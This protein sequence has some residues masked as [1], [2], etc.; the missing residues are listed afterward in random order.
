MS[1]LENV[2]MTT[3]GDNQD[4]IQYPEMKQPERVNLRT[5]GEPTSSRQ[6]FRITEITQEIPRVTSSS[7][8]PVVLQRP[9]NRCRT[10]GALLTGL[11]CW[12]FIFLMGLVIAGRGTYY[13]ERFVNEKCQMARRDCALAKTNC[14]HVPHY[15][16]TQDAA[17]RSEWEGEHK[18]NFR[19]IA[20][21]VLYNEPLYDARGV[22]STGKTTNFYV[23]VG[24]MGFMLSLAVSMWAYHGCLRDCTG[25]Q[26]FV[27]YTFD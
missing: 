10:V 19:E 15:C 16:E 20:H 3:M 23:G 17:I 12:T 4:E 26:R 24:A 21:R 22:K 2:E 5:K 18:L 14:N 13:D 8:R 27:G 25:T 11:S 1:T 9:T 7:R 6:N